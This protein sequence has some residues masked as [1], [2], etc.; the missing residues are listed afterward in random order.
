MRLLS[1]CQNLKQAKD[2][3]AEIDRRITLGESPFAKV[4]KVKGV[5]DLLDDFAAS[6]TNTAKV[7][8]RGRIKNHLQPKFR[9]MAL[10][11]V[12]VQVVMAW[13]AEMEAGGLSATTRLHNFGM[14]SRFFGWAIEQGLAEVNPCKAVPRKR[15]PKVQTSRVQEW[16]ESDEV[17]SSLIA[18][19]GTPVG[20]MF[21]IGNRA[22]LRPGEILGLRMSDL[23]F[24]DS[25]AIR[26]RYSLN[27]TL[28]EDKDKQGIVKWAPMPTDALEVLGPYLAAR[29]A[30]GA[31]PE[32]LVF[33]PP[34]KGKWRPAAE[35]QNWLGYHPKFLRRRWREVAPPGMSWYKASR[36]SFASR[37]LSEGAS[38]DEVS[39][40]L[41]HSN[42]NV[43][44]KHYDHFIR[45]EF[46]EGLRKPLSR[47]A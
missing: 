47:K 13:L 25:G 4:E 3:L 22:G 39:A 10:K 20:L 45:K 26:V 46:S 18:K 36:H 28:K 32:D 9:K 23:G 43:T 19:L 12:S 16:I 7:P 30:E 40:A 42:I 2:L 44:R 17:V 29:K 37:N 6:L 11:E 1:G 5:G 35:Y 31:G 38:L 8:D 34:R 33:V 41:G 24:L 14:L 15:R 27:K 21:W